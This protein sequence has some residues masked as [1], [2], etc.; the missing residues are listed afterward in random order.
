MKRL[1]L[2]MTV[3]LLLLT[4]GCAETQSTPKVSQPA[5][6]TPAEKVASA[7]TELAPVTP[8][9]AA[10]VA[11]TPVTPSAEPAKVRQPEVLLSSRNKEQ[12][13]IAFDF[14]GTPGMDKSKSLDERRQ[15]V[16]E[17]MAR[18]YQ[19]D[20]AKREKT[21]QKVKLFALGVPNRDD[22]LRGD[23]RNTDELAICET[24]H[25]LL[26]GNEAPL[27]RLG[28]IDWRAALK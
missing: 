18:L 16:A 7:K 15:Y 5:Q 14:A 21:G 1:N 11:P 6:E 25:E 12:L 24:T 22:Y 17:H 8:A 3:A 2:A 20:F 27:Q 23:F 9:V 4:F 28:T 10:N 26:V 19:Q 13:I